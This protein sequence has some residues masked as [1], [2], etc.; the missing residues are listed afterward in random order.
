MTSI[1]IKIL[2]SIASVSAV[3]A[4]ICQIQLSRKASKLGNWIQKERPDLLSEL[5]SFPKNYNG[6]YPGLK[7]LYRRNVVSNPMFNQQYEQL[8]F[9]GGAKASLGHRYGIILHWTGY[10]W[11]QMVGLAL[12][13]QLLGLV[14]MWISQIMQQRQPRQ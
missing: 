12:V 7:I 4:F 8:R 9:L 6:G 13:R 1:Q 10:Y 3:Y 2:I 11:F 5:N 14:W